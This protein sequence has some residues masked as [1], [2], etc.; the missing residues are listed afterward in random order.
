MQF[1]ERPPSTT[2]TEHDIAY[3]AGI[4]DGEGCIAITREF[5]GDRYHFNVV[6]VVAN[7]SLPVLEWLQ[8]RW[9]GHVP[10][11]TASRAPNQRPAGQWRSLS[12]RQIKGMLESILP[13]L[14]IKRAQAE[15]A[16]QMIAV[17]GVFYPG[18][19]GAKLPPHL[20]AEQERLYW[21]Q[22]ELNHRG[23][24]PFERKP[25]RLAK[26]PQ[27]EAAIRRRISSGETSSRCVATTHL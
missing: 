24:A 20:L 15:N 13:Y 8:D 25:G 4:V 27:V 11:L 22:R 6:V 19:R 12:G 9:G 18:G 23:T 7:T 16:L 17:M 3:T 5:R 2:P 14:Q 21:I 10:A 26:R 1:M